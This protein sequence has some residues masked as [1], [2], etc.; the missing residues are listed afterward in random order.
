VRAEATPAD[1]FRQEQS[2]H[3]YSHVADLF[4]MGGD[5]Q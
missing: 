2:R 5:V 1:F 4:G 3:G